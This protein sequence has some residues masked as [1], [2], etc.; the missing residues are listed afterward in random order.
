[1]SA[2]IGIAQSLNL[3]VVAEGVES[4]KPLALLRAKSCDEAEGFLVSRP[5]PAEQFADLVRVGLPAP[6]V[7]MQA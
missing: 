3:R 6:A 7:A 4:T 2:V 1:V 5:V